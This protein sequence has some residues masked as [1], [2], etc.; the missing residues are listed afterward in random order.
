MKMMK[1]IAVFSLAAMMA[2]S[3]VGCGKEV[4]KN[5]VFSVEDM[6]GK[7]IGVQTGTTGDTYATD[8]EKKNKGTTVERYNKGADAVQTLKQGKIDVVLIDEQPAKAFVEKNKDDLKILDEAFAKEEYAICIAKDNDA[9]TTEFN[10]AIAELKKDGTI[11]NIMK[12]YI[13]E[14][15]IGKY[16]YE[17]PTDVD[18]SKG[19]LT[20]AT[21]AEFK[22]YE[23][24]EKD[25]IVGI[26][27]DIAQAICDKLGYKLKIE[28]MQFDAIISAVNSGKA[29]FGGAGMTV[30]ED[31]LKNINFT[32]TYTTA[33][34]V[35]IVRSK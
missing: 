14:D 30:T 17:S 21:N 32:D 25:A 29:D 6:A 16:P 19:T 5:T 15:T 3:T 7:K 12:N 8:F 35:M 20:M 11:E 34:Q 22:P 28:D 10:T 13:G 23:Y 18:R 4:A 33:R 2:V 26:D 1:K 27:V 24:H 9:L 31:R